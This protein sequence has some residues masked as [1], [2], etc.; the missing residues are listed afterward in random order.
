MAKILA[1]RVALISDYHPG[2]SQHTFSSALL[3]ACGLWLS[4]CGSSESEGDSSRSSTSDPKPT[5]LPT[6]ELDSDTAGALYGEIL[7]EGEAPERFPIGARKKSECTTHADVEHLSSIEVVTDGKVASVLVRITRGF[8]ADDVPDAPAE[9]AVLDQRGCMYTPH[10]LAFQAGQAFEVR[11]SDPTTHNV[12]AK[13]VKNESPGNRNM[14]EGQAPLEISFPLAE[15]LI[16][17]KC[18]IHPWME[19]RVHVVEHPW[20]DVTGMDGTFRIDD[21]PPGT[22]SVEALHEKYGKLRARD[23]VVRAGKATGFALTFAP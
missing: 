7:F 18:D 21:V 19:A 16:H 4:A 22:Y 2:M 11:N 13:P 10:V 23:V 14:S 1:G 17:F 9:P 12:N 6:L 15:T 3:L 5:K 20:F 8:D